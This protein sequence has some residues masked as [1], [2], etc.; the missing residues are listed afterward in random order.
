MT[1]VVLCCC[2]WPIQSMDGLSPN[3]MTGHMDKLAKKSYTVPFC[4]FRANK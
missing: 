1:V 4:Y 3:I 2:I